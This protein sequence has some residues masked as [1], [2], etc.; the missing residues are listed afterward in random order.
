MNSQ[1]SRLGRRVVWGLTAAWERAGFLEMICVAFMVLCA[2]LA[3][4]VIQPLEAQKQLL[5]EERV[6]LEGQVA[7]T[8]KQSVNVKIAVDP[9]AEFLAGFPLNKEREP[10]IDR[11]HALANQSG[12]AIDRIDYRLEGL[13]TLPLQRMGMRITATGPYDTHR[14]F[15]HA[16]LKTFGNLAVE[17]I[18]LEKE[19]DSTVQLRV[20]L[21][22]SF[23]YRDSP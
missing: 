14:A 9:I 11:L 5:Q 20:S 12:I 10:Q 23:Y 7:R 17:N 6:V 3:W 19:K 1:I 4:Q 22:V 2:G 18:N 16:L 15:L 21:D 8:K 13:K